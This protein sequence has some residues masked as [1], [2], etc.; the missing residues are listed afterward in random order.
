MPLALNRAMS[1]GEAPNA[2]ASR[3]ATPDA[4]AA[5]VWA[6]LVE[7]IAA[8]GDRQAFATLFQHFA[9]RV[10]SYMMRLGAQ[11]AHAEELA[12]EAMIMVWRKAASFDRAQ[13]SVAT[14]LFT[15]A[16]NK[17]IDAIRR[18]RRPE[19]D[20]SDPAL[21]PDPEPPPDA[22]LDAGQRDA[23]LKAAIA[24]LPAE[25]AELLRLAFY[26]DKSHG[27]IAAERGIPLG[28]VKSRLRLAFG[29]LRK[30]M[31]GQV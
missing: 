16:R 4:A 9:P 13:S 21:V 24:T 2:P 19:I 20:P 14:W 17:R 23:R 12:Q 11:P 25:Q 6:E 28:T 26:E 5:A 7:R 18:E 15:I 10:K 31:E 29:R 8:S 30:A 1:Q 27:D 3:P 22:A